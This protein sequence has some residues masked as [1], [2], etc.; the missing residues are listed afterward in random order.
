MRLIF[1]LTASIVP[2]LLI[3]CAAKPEA[4]AQAQASASADKTASASPA[5]PKDAQWTI[6]CVSLK[7]AT[8]VEQMNQLKA[9]LMRTTGLRGWYVVHLEDHS[10]LYYGYYRSFKDKKD[11]A[12]AARLQKD[13]K[14]IQAIVDQSGNKPFRDAMPMLIA[15]PD[16]VAPPEW[17]LRNAKGYWSLQIAAY[18]GSPQRKQAAVDAVREARQQ[19]IEAYYYH[20]QS[21]SSVCIGA[22]P[23]NAVKKQDS[24]QAET[25]D[26]TQ[27]MLV[28][29]PGTDV[30]G[31]QT[32]G[33][34]EKSS[35]ERV[36]VVEERVEIA[37][38][39]L[40]AARKKYPHHIVNGS[41]EVISF[42]RPDGTVVDQQKPSLLVLI[43]RAA[44][45]SVL[46]PDPMSDQ[47][48]LLSPQGTDDDLARRLRSVGSGK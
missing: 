19:G 47:P 46:T 43:P 24:D 5:P 9:D 21:V 6:Y 20:G 4:G 11:P 42:K 27:P 37:D 14:S 15:A 10:A 2:F 38:P 48:N 30:L 40:E 26:P 44:T 22:W 1:W 28:L 23:E 3:S 33:L 29:G 35:G 8:H 16:P 32:K 36:H 13:Q 39:T 7:G 34:R 18:E 17:D 45:P 12:E 41:E 31:N 25:S